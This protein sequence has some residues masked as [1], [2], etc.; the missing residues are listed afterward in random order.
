MFDVDRICAEQ[1]ITNL[2]NFQ[3]VTHH[4]QTSNKDTNHFQTS[5]QTKISQCGFWYTTLQLDKLSPREQRHKIKNG[6]RMIICNFK[7][8]ES[9]ICYYKTIIFV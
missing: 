1:N 5:H 6:M 8:F 2:N 3:Y 9:I 4:F 7:N